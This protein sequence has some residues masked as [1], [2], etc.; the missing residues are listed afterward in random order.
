MTRNRIN[1]IVAVLNFIE[2]K[3]TRDGT[4]AV[5]CQDMEAVWRDA[6]FFKGRGLA[7]ERRAWGHAWRAERNAMA[8]LYNDL[9]KALE[10]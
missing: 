2:T 5:A 6:L 7:S 9:D 10:D 1:A 8:V 3:R 4:D